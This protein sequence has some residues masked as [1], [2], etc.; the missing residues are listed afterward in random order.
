M[1]GLPI[2]V[3]DDVV[4]RRPNKRSLNGI[5]VTSFGR[6]DGT[7]LRGYL[8]SVLLRYIPTL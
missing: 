6:P 3:P 7:S 8:H 2:V 1:G 5:F 4:H